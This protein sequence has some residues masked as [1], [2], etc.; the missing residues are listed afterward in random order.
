MERVSQNRFRK[1]NAFVINIIKNNPT[2]KR[3]I[4]MV[5]FVKSRER[6][7]LF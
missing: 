2:R 4:N 6:N 1:C 7:K 3:F 5:K